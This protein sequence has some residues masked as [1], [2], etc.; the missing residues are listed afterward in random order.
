MCVVLTG[1][2]DF[3]GSVPS[4]YHVGSLGDLLLLVR[5]EATS[6]A[7]VTDLQIAVHID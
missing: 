1:Q 6:Q 7:K 3:R 2:H 4:G 5:V